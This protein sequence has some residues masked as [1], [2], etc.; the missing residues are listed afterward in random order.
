MEQVPSQL[1]T[2]SGMGVTL[3][4]LTGYATSIVALLRH[5]A[6]LQKSLDLGF[7]LSRMQAT[8]KLLTMT[9]SQVSPYLLLQEVERPNN[10]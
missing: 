10:S 9:V 5:L 8:K 2:I 1:W 4:R 3:R 7:K 6:I